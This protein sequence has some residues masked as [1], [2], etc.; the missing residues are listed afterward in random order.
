MPAKSYLPSRLADRMLWLANFVAQLNATGVNYGF[1]TSEKAAMGTALADLQMTV[2]ANADAQEQARVARQEQEAALAAFLVTVRAAV[3]RLQAAPAMTDAARAQYQITIPDTSRTPVP[4]PTARPLADVDVSDRL[5][6][7]LRYHT[8]EDPARRAR[9]DGVA[10]V[11]V[12]LKIGGDAPPA[13][14]QMDLGGFTTRDSFTKT[15]TGADAGKTVWYCGVYYNTRGE[16]GPWGPVV[17]ATV[18]A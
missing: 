5:E 8:A 11:R 14:E 2:D 9:P 15:F 12:Y 16:T 18:A 6:H 4:P 7:T 3:R 1:T 13:P 17:A 10:G